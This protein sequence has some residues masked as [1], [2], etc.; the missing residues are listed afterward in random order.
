MKSDPSINVKAA[1]QNRGPLYLCKEVNQGHGQGRD[2]VPTPETKLRILSDEDAIEAPKFSSMTVR[3]S[4]FGLD[5]FQ[6]RWY[7]HLPQS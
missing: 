2:K 6:S 1:E 4:P 5:T 7:M 3:H